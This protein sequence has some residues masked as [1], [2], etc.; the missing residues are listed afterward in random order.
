MIAKGY[1]RAAEAMVLIVGKNECT[2]FYIRK[3]YSNNQQLQMKIVQII[4]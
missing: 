1:E 3:K 2:V 4:F